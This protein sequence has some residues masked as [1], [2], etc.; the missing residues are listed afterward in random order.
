MLPGDLIPTPF[1]TPPVTTLPPKK[2]SSFS[3][4]MAVEKVEV[5]S[6]PLHSLWFRHWPPGG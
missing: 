1:L 4:H 2:V 3:S 5:S 6:P